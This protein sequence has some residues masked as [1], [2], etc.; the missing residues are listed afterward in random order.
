MHITLVQFH[1]MQL[2]PSGKKSKDS[3]L[4]FFTQFADVTMDQINIL[5]AYSVHV[6]QKR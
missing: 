2:Q 1:S 4:D 3:V 5:A 6:Q